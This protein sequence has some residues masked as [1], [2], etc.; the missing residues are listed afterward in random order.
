MVDCKVGYKYCEEEMCPHYN[1]PPN[2][3]PKRKTEAPKARPLLVCLS[4]LLGG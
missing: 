4:V 3:C 2:D 1:G